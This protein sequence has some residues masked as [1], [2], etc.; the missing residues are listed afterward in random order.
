ML[1]QELSHLLSL[2]AAMEKPKAERSSKSD[3]KKNR[4]ALVDACGNKQIEDLRRLINIGAPLNILNER[5]DYANQRTP[6]AICAAHGWA[7]GIQELLEAGADES[8][9]PG[10]LFAADGQLHPEK[11]RPMSCLDVAAQASNATIFLLLFNMHGEELRLHSLSYVRNPGIFLAVDRLGYAKHLDPARQ[12]GI[13]RS[14]LPGLDPAAGVS[15]PGSDQRKAFD[16]LCSLL[17]VKTSPA[18]SSALWIDA[19]AQN[20]PGILQGLASRSI[21]PSDD[22]TIE[23][24]PSKATTSYYAPSAWIDLKDS[25]TRYDP[26]NK[27]KEFNA[28]ANVHTRVGLAS[29]A[30]ILHRPHGDRRNVHALVAIAP[31]REELMGNALAHH[32]I[33]QNP[34]VKL[35]RRLADLGCDVACIRDDNGRNPLHLAAKSQDSKATLEV[36]ARICT[37]WISQRDHDG[38]IPLDYENGERKSSLNLLFDQIGMREGMKGRLGKRHNPAKTRRL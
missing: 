12:Q 36:L 29:A 37:D 15:D 13:L 31:L 21:M 5:N 14:C 20:S 25:P 3:T 24:L 6:L 10:H 23:I 33:C 1:D 11:S 38:K 19:L 4:L 26:N 18:L 7:E 8:L 30:A 28:L 17:G 22:G 9:V 35:F 2:S 32:Y 34:D 16:A 27:S